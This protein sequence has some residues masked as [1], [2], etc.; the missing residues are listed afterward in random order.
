MARL[1]LLVRE[2]AIGHGEKLL[3]QV[4]CQLDLVK[5]VVR[6]G[7]K[8]Q[9]RRRLWQQSITN[10]D[11]L[12][13]GGGVVVL[14]RGE[15]EMAGGETEVVFGGKCVGLGDGALEKSFGFGVA[16]EVDEGVGVVVEEGGVW[17]GGSGDKGGEEGLGLIV[18]AVAAVE[19]SKE[20]GDCGVLGIGG[21]EFFG[22]G[23]SVGELAL[24][25]VEGGELGVEG[26]VAGIFGES[27]G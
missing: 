10:C 1:P 7:R 21:V 16:V 12:Q 17:R 5:F 19:T 20:P 13:R 23:E 14:G 9:G 15:G 8:E 25:G 22:D 4:D 2:L 24:G 11:R 6:S 18:L 3:V 26:G 27:C